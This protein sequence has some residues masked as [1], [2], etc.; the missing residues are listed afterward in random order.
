MNLVKQPFEKKEYFLLFKIIKF[1]QSEKEFQDFYFR[2][3]QTPCEHCNSTGFLI[4]HG[5]LHGYDEH[6]F[7]KRI[8]RGHRIFC[9]NRSHRTGCGRTFSIFCMN[10]MKRFTIS[11]YSFWR[12][13]DNV[14]HGMN[15]TQAFRRLNL[16]FSIST[17]F[18]LYNTFHTR[19]SRIRTLLFKLCPIP[20]L[21]KTLNP[22][23]QTILHLKAAFKYVTSPLPVFQQHFQTDFI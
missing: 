23:L 1:Y 9:S 10:I 18:R 4:L 15:K 16:I 20:V 2:L 7:G 8:I 11:S 14:S 19:Q 21:R 13:L 17:A 12:F 6:C 3:K 5:F 22:V